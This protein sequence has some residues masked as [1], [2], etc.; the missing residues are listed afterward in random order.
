MR[1]AATSGVLAAAALLLAP[2]AGA[3][4]PTVYF[5]YKTDCTF[6]VSVDGGGSTASLPPGV[7]QV[8]VNTITPFA[9]DPAAACSYPRFQ[10]TGPGVN[11]TTDLS[12]GG[13]TVAQFTAT[14]AAGATYVAQDLNQPAASRKTIGIATS[15]SSSSIAPVSGSTA[16]KGSDTNTGQDV[17]GSQALAGTVAA[18][19]SLSLTNGGTTVRTLTAGRYAVVVS[20]RSRTR[21]FVLVSPAK[22][23]V[24]L[25]TAGFVGTKRSTIA[26]TRGTW[27]FF[28]PA[29]VKSAFTVR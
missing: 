23:R 7:Y 9:E 16:S 4:S 10:L 8:Y 26:L 29:G 18:S 28:T 1:R 13:E 2:L 20:D 17:V 6:A 15:G 19:G 5:T 27:A 11:I 24:A 14:F 22:R 25:T 12:S 21:G 3:A